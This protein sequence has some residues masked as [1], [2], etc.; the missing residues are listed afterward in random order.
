MSF[1]IDKIA[2]LSRIAVTAEEQLQ[3]EPKLMTIV[4]MIDQLQSVDTTN[5]E[6]M[7][8][9]L[10]DYLCLRADQGTETNNREK[11]QAI[12]P[13]VASGLYIVPKVID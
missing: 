8:N 10:T 7:V 5:I 9:P 13:L 6:P 4:A 3:L 12:A 2:H 11:Y 1:N